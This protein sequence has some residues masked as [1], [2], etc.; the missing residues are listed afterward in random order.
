MFHYYTLEEVYNYAEK[1]GYSREDVEIVKEL[2]Y[3]YD[4]EEE[5]LLGYEVG[6]GHEYTE[7][8]VWE[9]ENLDEC[10]IDYEHMIWED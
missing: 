2:G 8:W 4:K 5:I 1:L 9:F 7:T 3:D 10:A 6:F